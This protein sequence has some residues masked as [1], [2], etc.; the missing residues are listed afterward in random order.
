V[1]TCKYYSLLHN[2]RWDFLPHDGLTRTKLL[3]T[4]NIPAVTLHPQSFSYNFGSLQMGEFPT[5]ELPGL[6]L[7]IK[8]ARNLDSDND[9]LL[10]I[11]NHTLIPYPYMSPTQNMGTY[12]RDT[13]L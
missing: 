6:L 1:I 13:A 10:A 3:W 2:C 12:K 11:I 5:H 4:G 8:L 9:E 7:S